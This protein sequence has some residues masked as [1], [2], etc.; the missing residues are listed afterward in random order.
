MPGIRRGWSGWSGR[1][2]RCAAS[3]CTWGWSGRPGVEGAGDG[4]YR[5]FVP[6]LPPALPLLAIL[7]HPGGAEVSAAAAAWALKPLALGP[8]AGLSM[9][10]EPRPDHRRAS[11][12]PPRRG[13]RAPKPRPGRR[14]PPSRPRPRQ[15]RSGRSGSP[16]EI[17]RQRGR[18]G[19]RPGLDT[20]PAGVDLTRDGLGDACLD[21]AVEGM[22]GSHRARRRPTGRRGRRCRR[23]R[24]VARETPRSGSSPGCC[25]TRTAG[26]RRRGTSRRGSPCGTT[27]APAGRATGATATRHLPRRPSAHREPG[28]ADPRGDAGGEETCRRLVAEAARAAAALTAARDHPHGALGHRPHSRV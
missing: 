2:R 19:G 11:R 15:R 27:R 17:H 10:R 1:R 20:E 16:D 25:W 26:G 14:P 24:S 13:G 28:A 21:A 4:V 6:T 7:R 12:P 18:A 8:A 23:R 9:R 22:L 5:V 3:G